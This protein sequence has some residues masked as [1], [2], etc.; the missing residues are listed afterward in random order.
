VDPPAPLLCIFRPLVAVV[1]GVQL[2]CC[3]PQQP[4]PARRRP[5]RGS[6]RS[7]ALHLPSARVRAAAGRQSGSPPAVPAAQLAG[8]PGHPSVP[9]AGLPT[10]GWSSSCRPSICWSHKHLPSGDFFLCSSLFL[11]HSV[12]ILSCSFMLPQASFG[13]EQRKRLYVNLCLFLAHHLPLLRCHV[14]SNFSSG[15]SF[16]FPWPASHGYAVAI[17]SNFLLGLCRHLQVACYLCNQ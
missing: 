17:C 3:S 7:L 9:L 15:S 10:H 14:A 12:H 1:G 8:P 2:L 16:L 11:L 13:G 5:H 6:A 4:P